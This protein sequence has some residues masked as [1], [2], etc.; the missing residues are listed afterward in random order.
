MRRIIQIKGNHG[1]GKT[2]LLN[3][4]I[5]N[6]NLKKV[7]FL[8]NSH[9][10]CLLF[11]ENIVILAYQKSKDGSF[12][13]IDAIIR[14]GNDLIKYIK[15]IINKFSPRD[16]IYE[17][18]IYGETLQLAQNIDK[19]SRE[20][21]YQY[22]NFFLHATAQQSIKRVLLRNGGTSINFKTIKN[23]FERYGR[24]VEDLKNSGQIVQIIDTDN[25]S[26]KDVLSKFEGLLL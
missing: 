7:A 2:T 22:V 4:L 10:C 9:N 26:P 15:V 12:N 21:R 24:L 18:A 23:K 17:G 5:K 1:S 13:G 3:N 6:R 25:L 16:L 14:D 19:L 8:P 11:D 20:S